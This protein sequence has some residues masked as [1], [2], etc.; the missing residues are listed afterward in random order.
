MN[1]MSISFRLGKPSAPHGANLAHNNREFSASNI[2][3]ERTCENIQFQRERLE[4]A[5]AALFSEALE[6]YNAK[7]NRPCRRIHDYCQHVKDSHR[8]EPYYE[9]I[10]REACL[11]VSVSEMQMRRTIHWHRL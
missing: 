6:A 2:M 4:D 10:H 7:Q 1:Q 9:V 8:E 5:Y 3:P 11:S